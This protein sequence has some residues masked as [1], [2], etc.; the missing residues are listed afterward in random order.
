MNIDRFI[1]FDLKMFISF[2]I[3]HMQERS[4]LKVRLDELS[5][6]NRLL[7]LKGVITLLPLLLLAG[8][9]FLS[10]FHLCWPWPFQSP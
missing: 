5:C 8:I 6:S 2:S 9:M 4:T 1:Y 3:F 10:F 7:M